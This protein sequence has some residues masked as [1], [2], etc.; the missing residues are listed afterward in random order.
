[1]TG[2]TIIH[3]PNW[4]GDMVMATPFLL[5]VRACL[6]DEI[7][8]FGKSRAMQ[9]YHGL[10]LFDRFIPHDDKNPVTFLDNVSKLRSLRFERGLILPH[11]FRSAL[12]FFLGAVRERIGYARNHRD[13]LLTGRLAGTPSPEPTVEH[14]LKIVDHIGQ[15][16]VTEEPSLSV[17]GE[18][19]RRFDEVYMD[20]GGRYAVL[21]V[22]AEYGPSKRWPE[23]HFA[24]LADMLADEHGLKTYILPGLNEV[25]TA[26]RVMEGVKRKDAVS[27]KLMGLGD[28][29]VCLSRALLVV[30]NDTGPRH[31]AAA[32]GRPTIV[33]LGPMDDTYTRYPTAVTHTLS[34]EAPCRPCNRRK[35][36]RGHECLRDLRPEH[37][38]EKVRGILSEAH[39]RAG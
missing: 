28:L 29:K 19:D 34:I 36:D 7:W 9:L 14:Y 17:T 39:V 16:R 3:L 8:A 38:F 21:I 1:M 32:L 18:E 12:L 22:G 2:K 24:A 35:C 13:L 10:D 31:I 27:I 26:R 33:L 23:A 5:S 6:R 37:V 15:P 4:L 25:G 30:S 11:S 20:V